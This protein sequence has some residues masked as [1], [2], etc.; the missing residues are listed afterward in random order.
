MTDLLGNNVYE[1]PDCMN[2]KL[3]FKEASKEA[4][5]IFGLESK[6]IGEIEDK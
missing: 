1:F 2:F 3:I 4:I 6:K 5:N